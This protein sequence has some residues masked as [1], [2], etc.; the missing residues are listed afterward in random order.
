MG[1]LEKMFKKE[2]NNFNENIAIE[3]DIIERGKENNIEKNNVSLD[4]EKDLF[5]KEELEDNIEEKLYLEH[6]E[7]IKNENYEY[8]PLEILNYKTEKPKINKKDIE[9]MVIKLQRIFY[10]FGISVKVQNV[11]LGPSIIIYQIELASGVTISKITR[12]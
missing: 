11:V 4:N 10:S 12:L 3:K 5:K 6:T 8:P 9:E 7:I 1:I 2:S